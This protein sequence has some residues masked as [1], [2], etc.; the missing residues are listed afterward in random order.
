MNINS[1]VYDCGRIIQQTVISKIDI[2]ILKH[3]IDLEYST[4]LYVKT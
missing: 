2:L 3:V 4:E 1:V